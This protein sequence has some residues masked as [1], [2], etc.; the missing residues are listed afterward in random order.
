VLV[1]RAVVKLPPLLIL[2]EP[3]AGLDDDN[4]TIFIR[5]INALAALKKMAIVYISH[6]TEPKI[7]PEKILE[8]LPGENG[9]LS[10]IS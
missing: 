1:I 7:Q 5:L 9:S 2:D 6:R 10:K 3:T 8:L 4:T